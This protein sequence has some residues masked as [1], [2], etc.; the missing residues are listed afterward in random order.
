MQI[1]KVND[2]NDVAVFD[3]K[4]DCC[5]STNG[6]CRLLRILSTVFDNVHTVDAD[7]FT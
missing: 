4:G 6:H 3:L 7:L 5:V 1:D 2:L